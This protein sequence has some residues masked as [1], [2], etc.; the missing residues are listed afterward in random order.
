MQGHDGGIRKSEDGRVCVVTYHGDFNYS[1]INNLGESYAGGDYVLLL[2]N[3]TEVITANW[4]EE[5]L[6][7]AQS[8][9][10]GGSGRK[11]LLWG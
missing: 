11:A 10:C 9:R 3:D 4:M 1:A 6:M 8:G 2:N 5:L 7:Y